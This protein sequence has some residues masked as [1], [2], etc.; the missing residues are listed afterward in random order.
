MEALCA[1]EYVFAVDVSKMLTVQARKWGILFQSLGG[2]SLG[3]EKARVTPY[4]HGMVY[5]VPRFMTKHEGIKKFTGQGKSSLRLPYS[6]TGV[7]SYQL[8]TLLIHVGCPKTYIPMES[9]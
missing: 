7:F 9:L 1:C 3:Y 8:L 5:H 4:M 6:L 2:R